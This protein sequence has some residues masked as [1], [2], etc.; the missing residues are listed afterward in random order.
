MFCGKCGVQIEDGARFCPKCGN[1][2][3]AQP[4]AAKPEAAQPETAQ[5]ET[6]QPEAAQQSP[7]KKKRGKGKL[8]ALLAVVA[9]L[10]I[11][12][13]GFACYYLSPQQQYNRAMKKGDACM[14]EK[15]YQAAIAFYESAL[16]IEDSKDAQKAMAKAYIKC[17]DKS[18][19]EKSYTEAIEL[20]L[21][22][23]GYDKRNDSISR[24]LVAAYTGAGADS[25]ANADYQAAKEYYEE[26]LALD[27][28]S[29]EAKTG[30]INCL[31]GIG[32]EAL[33][34]ADETTARSCFEE[35]LAYDETNPT[36]CSGLAHLMA[37]DGSVSEAIAWL[38]EL[39]NEIGEN[40]ELLEEKEYLLEN[41]VVVSKKTTYEEG[42]YVTEDYNDDGSVLYKSFDWRGKLIQ[43]YLDD[44]DGKRLYYK[45]YADGELRSEENNTYDGKG[46][47]LTNVYRNYVDPEY[48]ARTE[49]TYTPEG[50]LTLQET[51]SL[52]E[53]YLLTYY[54]AEY[55]DGMMTSCRDAY[56]DY[57]THEFTE[58]YR[59][60]IK[61]NEHKD[62][63]EN[64]DGR[65][66][67]TDGYYFW[68]NGT[69]YQIDYDSNGNLIYR[70]GNTV[71][72]DYD[73]LENYTEETFA[74]DA[75]GNVVRTT[76]LSYQ[77][78]Y[79][80]DVSQV[81]SEEESSY[82]ADGTI[83]HNVYEYNADGSWGSSWNRSENVYDEEGRIVN[84]FYES[85]TVSREENYEYDEYGNEISWNSTDSYGNDYYRQ[86]Y[87]EYDGLG[88]MTSLVNL[89]DNY[90]YRVQY[91]YTYKMK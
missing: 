55:T 5:P 76:W 18:V 40:R 54:K 4:E 24:G 25:L 89:S 43:E 63:V 35:V 19:Q 82:Y 75:D 33:A 8:I 37:M 83:A 9:V 79:Y 66:S 32:K 31:A 58:E 26:A 87:Y 2:I 36:A 88:N 62:I 65:Y 41:A 57:D 69:T 28:D 34:S 1:A 78:D 81:Y 45:E 73:D 56:A 6:V 29:E 22:A 77:V 42:N 86:T 64:H 13:G 59:Q 60:E 3:A 68:E 48:S 80:G 38:D 30:R 52:E 12:A 50:D 21:A 20:Y 46:N 10:A 72:R 85:D 71:R 61:Y 23:Q 14:D 47:I 49:Y 7:A 17:A 70:R 11:G 27:A 39:I 51:Y 67:L 91:E 53:G 74:Y 16:E 84:S 15:D 44:K 90:D